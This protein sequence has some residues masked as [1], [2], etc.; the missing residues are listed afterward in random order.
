MTLSMKSSSFFTKLHARQYNN[1]Q[2]GEPEW[3]GRYLDDLGNRMTVLA[4]GNPEKGSNL[5]PKG[6]QDPE[7]IG[8][9][10]GSGHGILKFNRNSG[11]VTFEMW[12]LQF[13]ANDPKPED[14]FEG[15]PKLIRLKN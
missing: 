8:H 14:Q 15:F 1:H 11:E 3:T 2:A 6:V 13:D 12:R 10:K 5:I 9:Q 4:V 7:S